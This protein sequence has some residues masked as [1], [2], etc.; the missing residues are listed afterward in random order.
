MPFRLLLYRY[1]FFSWLFQDVNRGNAFE[2]LAAWRHNKDQA[3]WL[4]VYMRRWL[5]LGLLFYGL[6]AFTETA[7]SAPVLSSFLYV[8]GVL[9]VPVNAVIVVAWAGFKT[10]SGPL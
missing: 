2:R 10:L 4:P 7:L 1:F 9:S 6:G 5:G 3:R 8:P